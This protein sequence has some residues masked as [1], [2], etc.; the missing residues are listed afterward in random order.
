MV[1]GFWGRKVGMT[2]IFSED[3]KVIPVTAIDA[4]GW[5]VSQI[6]TLDGDGYN[7]IQ[8]ACL[9]KKYQNESFQMSWLTQKSKFFLWVKEITVDQVPEDIKQG[10]SFNFANTVKEKDVVDAIGVTKGCG[11]AGVIRRHGY[12]GGPRSHGSNFKRKPGSIGFMCATGKV[13]K[14][15]PMPGHMGVKRRTT[16]NLKIARIML[17]D[18]VVLVQGSMAGKPG[19]LIYVRK[20][21]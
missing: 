19:S 20:C 18:N 4:S 6:K 7:A 3:N 21:G 9:R 16:K 17:D 11:F 5:I 2:Q 15:K 1:H 8:V 10:Q 14:G 13:I 12:A